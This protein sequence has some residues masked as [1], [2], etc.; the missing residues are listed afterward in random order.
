MDFRSQGE[1]YVSNKFKTCLIILNY[2]YF[3]HKNYN[4]LMDY[5][6]QSVITK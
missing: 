6:F 1:D 3:L 5:T 2:I 4:N